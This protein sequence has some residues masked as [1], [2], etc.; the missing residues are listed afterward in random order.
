MPPFIVVFFWF[1]CTP[2]PPPSPPGG[3]ST[4]FYTGRL[5]PETQTLTFYIPFLIEMVPP[6]YTFHRK[7]YP[8]YIID[9]NEKEKKSKEKATRARE[10]DLSR[11]FGKSSCPS[12]AGGF[13]ILQVVNFLP[14][15]KYLQPE[16][17]TPF[18]RSYRK[19]LT[20]LGRRNLR[21]S[22]RSLRWLCV[23]VMQV[24]ISINYP[25]IKFRLH[26]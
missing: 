8:F 16:K 12:P 14:F 15:L 11:Y 21:G 7:W 1:C 25:R 26:F 5:H 17:G 22:L 10:L 3:Y 9:C 13:S 2:P 18:G 20:S 23:M 6:S 4:K 24:N 19:E